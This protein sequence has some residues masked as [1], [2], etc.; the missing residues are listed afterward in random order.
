[1]P[2]PSPVS[3]STAND[4]EGTAIT[5]SPT[6]A[7]VLPPV[8]VPWLVGLVGLA[9]LGAQLLPPNTIAAHVCA[10]IFSLGA[11]LGLASPGLRR[12]P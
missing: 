5:V 8:I 12:A 11:L 7:P 6:G 1:M 3:L 2:S 9:G 10:G 4:Q